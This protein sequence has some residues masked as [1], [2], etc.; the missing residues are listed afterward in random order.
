[1]QVNKDK[2]LSYG[3][4]DMGNVFMIDHAP[5]E[6]PR[7]PSEPV[8]K[9]YKQFSPIAKPQPPKLFEEKAQSNKHL[10][11]ND[12]SSLQKLIEKK[13]ESE[14]ELTRRKRR[15]RDELLGYGIEMKIY[16][17]DCRKRE[18]EI[19]KD[20]EEVD[21]FNA[22]QR[23]Y[24]TQDM[25]K[26][27]CQIDEYNTPH[28]YIFKN[29]KQ[30]IFSRGIKWPYQN[31]TPEMVAVWYLSYI[32]FD[33]EENYGNEFVVCMGTSSSTTTWEENKRKATQIMLSVYDLVENVCKNDKRFFMS[34][35][36]DDL[37]THTQILPFSSEKKNL[38]SIF[39]FP[40]AYANIN[41][42]AQQ[43]K[44][45]VGLNAIV[46]IGGGTT[47]I[48]IFSAYKKTEEQ[49]NEC[50]E[51]FDYISIPCGVNAIEEYGKDEHFRKVRKCIQD[52][53]DKLKSYAASIGVS[54]EESIPLTNFRPIVYSGG[55]SLRRELC[56]VYGGF[57]DIIHITTDMVSDTSIDEISKISNSIAMLNTA[58][59]LAKC[60]PDDS[61]IKLHSYD[62]LFSELKR[63]YKDK[64]RDERT[65]Q[66]YE[67]GLL[68]D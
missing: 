56:K 63:A 5:G 29:F 7:K 57:S 3:F 26:Y 54:K 16:E 61:D 23:E 32:F 59:G 25:K 65:K 67:Y 47:D 39:V 40:E 35:T 38:Y 64:K 53:T 44:F 14:K 21:R 22:I 37:I 30:A 13:K 28:P 17:K 8:Y 58:L 62:R 49:N 6:P 27:E 9:Q 19:K 10:V 12:L 15:E 18:I 1:M 31:V 24:Y 41:P 36:I 46:D 45:G 66:H 20:K 11:T 43:G 2:T 48:S 34:L 42:L 60:E 33:I 68:D 52:I 50:V 51:I 55:G 4:T